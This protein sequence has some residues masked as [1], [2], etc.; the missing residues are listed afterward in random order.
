M[1][2]LLLILTF[3]TLN[4]YAVDIQK[5]RELSYNKKE[6]VIS[7]FNL[8]YNIPRSI[9]MSAAPPADAFRGTL[10]GHEVAVYNN[11]IFSNSLYGYRAVVKSGGDWL[12]LSEPTYNLSD[13]NSRQ[14]C[15]D[16]AEIL[17]SIINQD[18]YDVLSTGGGDPEPEFGIALM[19]Y[20]LSDKAKVSNNEIVI[21]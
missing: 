21:D 9:V 8:G 16:V 1:K 18:A 4:S 7:G 3:I 6:Q 13:L 14:D 17:I 11:E 20:I 10:Y 5:I 19:K 15:Y 2:Y 12:Y